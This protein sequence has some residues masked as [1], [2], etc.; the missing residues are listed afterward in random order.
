LI[1]QMSRVGIDSD[2]KRTCTTS[3]F[4]DRLTLVSFPLETFVFK[5]TR[6][7]VSEFMQ[8]VPEGSTVVIESSTTGK[9]IS[10]MLSGKL[11]C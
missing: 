1:E 5:T 9:V 7:G 2:K 3:V 8:K 10:R 11:L 4:A 6:Q